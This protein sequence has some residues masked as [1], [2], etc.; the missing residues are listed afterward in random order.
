MFNL[1]LLKTFVILAKTQ[2]FRATA[3]ANSITQSAVSQQILSLEAKLRCKLVDR[4]KKQAVLTR[5]G[6]IF[7]TYAENILNQY[8]EAISQL[9]EQNEMMDGIIKVATI[10]SIGFYR[11]QPI[12][13]RFLRKHP[14]VQ[15]HLEYYHNN[16]IYEKVRTNIVDF[17]FVAYP[18]E[19]DKVRSQYFVD[20]QLV[21]AQCTQRP[22]FKKKMVDMDDLNGCRYISL[23]RTTPTGKEITAALKKAGVNLLVEFEFENVETLKSAILVGMGC[24][25]VPVNILN[26]ELQRKELEIVNIRGFGI[27]R[28]LGILFPH[29]KVL[30]KPKKKFFDT[31]A[32]T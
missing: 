3:Q 12:I 6:Q 29:G 8:D 23:S 2:S 1:I 27:T 17:G 15:I 28:P 31:F 25:F 26:N 11:L 20:D 30:T 9:Q 19:A 14:Q 24:A 22:V 4:S 18:R 7:M 16:V 10:Y 32:G 21:L 5:Q 13:R